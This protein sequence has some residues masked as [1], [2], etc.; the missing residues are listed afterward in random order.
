MYSKPVQ[1]SLS[2]GALPLA[3]EVMD[4]AYE[5]A[6]SEGHTRWSLRH[7]EI[8]R[9][10]WLRAYPDI[11]QISRDELDAE[12]REAESVQGTERD[13]GESGLIVTRQVAKLVKDGLVRHHAGYRSGRGLVVLTEAGREK[14][15]KG[16]SG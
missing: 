9:E 3:D 8:L 5:R 12:V 10:E 11:D 6:L 7:F 2:E 13:A 4:L 16:V 1:V 15:T 14:L